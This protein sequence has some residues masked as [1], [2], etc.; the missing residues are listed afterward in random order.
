M[1]PYSFLHQHARLALLGSALLAS[2][3]AHAT[4]TTLDAGNFN[5]SF[6]TSAFQISYVFANS[7]TSVDGWG[8][9]ASQYKVSAGNDSLR[10]DFTPLPSGA[11][12][13]NPSH[14]GDTS[15]PAVNVSAY[16]DANFGLNLPLSL[17]AD[18]AANT[19]YRITFGTTLGSSTYGFGGYTG[20]NGEGFYA[21]GHVFGSLTA[22]AAG[23][24]ATEL[25]PLNL[26]TSHL[27][28]TTSYPLGGTLNPGFELA[29]LGGSFKVTGPY[30]KPCCGALTKFSLDYIQ[31]DA[32]RAVPGVPEPGTYA[33][34]AL[35][36]A[37]LGLVARRRVQPR[38][39]A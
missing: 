7:S 6:D 13:A 21:D 12:G 31:I 4:A 39:Q 15:M 24:A 32:I 9:Q 18:D 3:M 16:Y 25:A 8:L 11:P 28:T 29:A 2:Q 37:G 35:G 23:Q 1:S 5:A 22:T 33:L 38:A 20:I 27:G 19:A 10:I 36:L 17:Q 30:S 26:A 14:Y 34:M